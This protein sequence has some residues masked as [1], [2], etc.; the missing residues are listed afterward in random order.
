MGQFHTVKNHLIEW[1][2]G[3]RGVPVSVQNLV[4]HK[5]VLMGDC[6]V[7]AA[8]ERIGHTSITVKLDV[9]V[10][11]KESREMEQVTEGRFVFVAINEQWKPVPIA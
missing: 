5:P 6:A 10:E 3:V 1:I 2:L 7:Y 9:L 8:T 11:R 4:F